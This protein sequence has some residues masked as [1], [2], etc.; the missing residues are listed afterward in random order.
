MKTK[1]MTIDKYI[2]LLLGKAEWYIDLAENHRVITGQG[3]FDHNARLYQGMETAILKIA[4]DLSVMND[5]DIS[6]ELERL[7][8]DMQEGYI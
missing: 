1:K 5:I 3:D 6:A 2:Y 4:L 8:P 7:A